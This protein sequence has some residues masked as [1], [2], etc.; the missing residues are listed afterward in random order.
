MVAINTIVNKTE[1]INN[2]TAEVRAEVKNRTVWST[3]FSPAELGFP[4][5]YLDS[6]DPDGPTTAELT[7]PVVVASILAGS[8]QNWI[9]TYSKHRKFRFRRIRQRS[10]SNYP[11]GDLLEYDSTNITS[12]V[13]GS[14]VPTPDTGAETGLQT[15]EDAN[16]DAIASA[17]QIEAGEDIKS[18]TYNNFISALYSK[19]DEIKDNN[20][21][22]TYTY[23]HDSC[24]S[25]CHSNCHASGRSRR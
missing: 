10:G 1:Q 18:T 9:K 17:Q 8:L 25:S 15:G 7:S 6:W 21:Q 16:I 22:Y 19:W 2:F 23:C 3:S 11:T 24:H 12:L 4:L 13:P 14:L 5:S 20:V